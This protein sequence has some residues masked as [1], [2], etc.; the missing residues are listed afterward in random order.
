MSAL[1]LYKSLG[2]ENQ[3]HVLPGC[4]SVAPGLSSWW[5][6]LY[7]ISTNQDCSPESQHFLFIIV[8]AFPQR[9]GTV[10]LLSLLYIGDWRK[11]ESFSTAL[12]VRSV[13]AES[14]ACGWPASLHGASQGLHHSEGEGG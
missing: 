9:L 14:G 11:H 2:I 1:K 7:N 8:L 5:Q 3:C 13:Q 6:I 10:W 12:I 4:F